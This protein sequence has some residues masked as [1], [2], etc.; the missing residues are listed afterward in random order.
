MMTWR[1][2]RTNCRNSISS[3]PATTESPKQMSIFASISK[4]KLELFDVSSVKKTDRAKEQIATLNKNCSLF[5]GFLLA[6]KQE[7]A[8]WKNFFHMRTKD[9]RLHCHKMVHSDLAT[10]LTCSSASKRFILRPVKYLP[11]MQS[12]L[13]ELPLLIWCSQWEARPSQDYAENCFIPYLQTEVRNVKRLEIV[14]D[15]YLPNSLKPATREKQ[16]AGKR[17]R[18]EGSTEI[19]AKWGSFLRND[20]NKSK[21]FHFLSDFIH[22]NFRLAGK[23]VVA[24]VNE[25]ILTFLDRN[26]EFLQPCNHEDAD[27][28]MFVHVND[29]ITQDNFRSVLIRSVDTD[30]VVLAVNA[31]YR[32]NVGIFVAFGTGNSFRCIEAHQLAQKLGPEKCIERCFRALQDVTPCL[33]FL[34]GVKC[35]LGQCGIC[36]MMSPECSALCQWILRIFI[37]KCQFWNFLWCCYT[38]RQVAS[39]KWLNLAS[40]CFRLWTD[41]LTIYNKQQHHWSNIQR[42]LCFRQ[43]SGIRLIGRKRV[44]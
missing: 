18:V 17:R 21:L 6:A 40:S 26:N 4:N 3:N 35:L 2:N 16:G 41:R 12:S 22:K 1:N 44:N 34:V 24:T 37:Q 28:R 23:T 32:F 8:T 14:W 27:M 5:R 11:Q 36:L 30:V 31:T 7:R 20:Q 43:I 38:T 19:P 42:E 33:S 9:F 25:H 10:K 39:W 29:T 15:I 13:T